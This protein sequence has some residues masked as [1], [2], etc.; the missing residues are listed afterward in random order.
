MK[1]SYTLSQYIPV[2]RR[3][4]TADGEGKELYRHHA[5]DML[6]AAD[7]RGFKTHIIHDG[8]LREPYRNESGPRFPHNVHYSP[9]DTPL[10]YGLPTKRCL[11][12]LLSL[13]KDKSDLI[14]SFAFTYD[15]TMILK[16]LPMEK[17]WEFGKNGYTEWEGYVISGIP[18]K[19]FQ[20]EKDGRKAKAWDVFSYWQ[21]SFARALT[22]NIALFADDPRKLKKIANIIRMKKERAH[23][24]TMSNAEILEYCYSE[25]EYLSMLYRDLLTHCDVLGYKQ[26]SHFGPGSVASAFFVK[27]ELKKS[28]PWGSHAS[29]LCGLPPYVAEHSYYGG[30]FEISIQGLAEDL[31]EYDIQSA[32]PSIAVQLPRL[33]T[34]HFE[35]VKDFDPRYRWGFY[36]V[37]SRT[38]GPW[39]PFPFRADNENGKEYLNGATKGAIAFVHGGRRWVTADEVRTARKYFGDDAIPVYDGWVFIPGDDYKPFAKILEMYLWRKIGNP[40]CSE[41]IAGHK[42]VY[43]CSKH[44]PPTDGLSMVIKLMINSIYGK[45]AQ[46]IGWR[47]ANPE[48]G[49]DS[50]LA[51]NAPEYQCY[52]YAA[53]IT[54]GTRAKVME[55][56]LIGGRKDDCPDCRSGD[57]FR[58]CDTHS[59]VKSIATDGILSTEEI[60]ELYTHDYELGAWE[61]ATKPDAWLGMPGIYSFKDIGEPD[62]CDVCR[63]N[64]LACDDH[65]SV[66]KYK[67]RGLDSKYFP[68]THLRDAWERGL[69]NI[70]PVGEPDCPDCIKRHEACLQVVKSPVTGEPEYHGIRAFMPLRQAL[71]RTNGL[72]LMGEWIPLKK[73]VKFRSVQHK[74]NYPEIDDDDFL[75]PHGS[76]IDL[77]SITVPYDLKSEP[78]EPKQSWEQVHAGRAEDPDIPMWDDMEDIPEYGE[79]GL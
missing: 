25:C 27:Q 36:Y 51:Y 5:Y 41:C 4:V 48:Y 28:L 59:I 21:M 46:S 50:P 69:W 66:K 6:A 10:N 26:N 8:S 22:A 7:D 76:A 55:A 31:I 49:L 45:L 70:G 78:F 71:T 56:A 17:L 72:D 44:P 43:F 47:I 64:G 60:P 53:L 12:F 11:D 54:G 29:T 39:A 20:V 38:S 33:K 42:G 77:T 3:I 30:R 24:N 34:G 2:N 23:F 57:M 32:Y 16:D 13:P 63:A 19:F 14:I 35:R 15:Y 67:R 75:M 74:R 73:R 1:S 58:A 79:L 61:K 18:R 9:D 65:L 40:N 52:I 68:A 62:K 37:G